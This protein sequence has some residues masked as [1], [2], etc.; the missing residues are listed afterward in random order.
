MNK[1]WFTVFVSL[2]YLIV[3]SFSLLS[4]QDA[5]LKQK[6]QEMRRWTG[7]EN[8]V[9]ILFEVKVTAVEK[10]KRQTEFNHNFSISL[11]Y[12]YASKKL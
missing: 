11:K 7:K 9:W 1:L 8:L 10:V 12:L 3:H 5:K 6:T 4:F 2:K